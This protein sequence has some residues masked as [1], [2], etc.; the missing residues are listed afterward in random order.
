MGVVFGICPK[1]KGQ[2]KI[3]YRIWD[4]TQIIDHFIRYNEGASLDNTSLTLEL[5][6][7]NCPLCDGDGFNDWV[8]VTRRGNVLKNFKIVKGNMDIYR[9]KCLP[10]GVPNPKYHRECIE[11]YRM[12]QKPEKLIELS[13]RHYINIKLNKKIL[14]MSTGELS[15]VRDKCF[16]YERELFHLKGNDLTGNELRKI[17][18]SIGLSDFL[19]DKFAYPGPYDYPWNAFN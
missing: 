11:I 2:G 19:P 4:S 1:C 5:L 16:R 8:R 9:M 3:R 13:Q 15:D 6:K 14:S 18:K 17:F 12:F 10:Y 7:I